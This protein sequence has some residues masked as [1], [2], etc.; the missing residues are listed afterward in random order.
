MKKNSIKSQLSL[1]KIS[2]LAL[3]ISIPANFYLNSLADSSRQTILKGVTIEKDFSEL[4]LLER[5]S[6][7]KLQNHE[8][9]SLKQESLLSTISFFHSPELN[10]LLDERKTI[11]NQLVT[12]SNK[13]S[14]LLLDVHSTIIDLIVSTKYI[15]EHHIAYLKNFMRRGELKQDYDIGENFKRSP[16]HA[17]PEIEIIRVAATIQSSLVDLLDSFN[18]IYLSFHKDSKKDH[19]NGIVSK[20]YASVNTF[21]DYSLDAQDGLLVEELLT[22]GRDLEKQFNL[23]IYLENQKHIN[24]ATLDD[25]RTK[26]RQILEGIENDLDN[27]FSRMLSI[28][29]ILQIFII[30]FVLVLIS[31]ISISGKRI[32][33]EINRTIT[34]TEKINNDLS[35]QIPPEAN[36][37][38]EFKLVFETMNTMAARI[39]VSM[40]ELQKAHCELEKRVEERTIELTESNTQLIKEI[41]ERKQAET[42]KEKL[43]DQLQQTQK[44]EAIGTLAG[45]IAHDFNNILTAILGFAELAKMKNKAGQSLD[46]EIETILQSANRAKGLV[47]QILTFSRQSK[48]DIHALSI[49]PIIK[50]AGK[51]MRASIPTTI[52]ITEDIDPVVGPIMADPTQI[53][54]I[55]MNL[56]SN[57]AHAMEDKGGTLKITLESFHLGDEQQHLMLYLPQGEYA[58]LTVS[59]TGHGMD[60]TVK[61]RIFEPFFTTK[62]VGKGTGMGLSVVH[63]IVKSYNGAITF[64]SRLGEGTIFNIYLP[65]TE[66]VPVKIDHQ[67]H[68]PPVAGGEKILLIDDEVV[69]VEMLRKSLAFFGYNVDAVTDSKEA[70][71]LFQKNQEKYDV[72]ITD[73]TMPQMTGLELAREIRKIRADIPVILCSGYSTL[74]TEKN[75]KDLFISEFVT[76][77]STGLKLATVIRKVIDSIP[78]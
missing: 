1:L 55:I 42:E 5:D 22:K 40:Q 10:R 48:Q 69:I 21:E 6:L 57:A 28:I 70:L 65:L 34:E 2:L 45:G 77:P 17:A 26:I 4:F 54:Q 11:Y 29:K 49:Q 33:A 13:A 52:S 53:H 64:E 31:L 56:C 37:F 63:G 43:R 76:K 12:E 66:G 74:V 3:L 25:N 7:T 78:P 14:E 35:Y 60:E 61:E 18:D 67:T 44:L 9:T 23:L 24:L 36:T 16:V 62:S 19:F 30:V 38:D 58:K 32:I 68:G 41:E 39:N 71:R 51:L 73:Q 47:K 8:Q 72:I 20:F 27:S 46:N 50:E 75:K 15:H 59:D